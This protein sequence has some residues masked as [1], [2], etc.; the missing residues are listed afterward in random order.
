MSGRLD[1]QW[2]RTGVLSVRGAD[3]AAYEQL[4]LSLTVRSGGGSRV[5]G[6]GTLMQSSGNSVQSTSTTLQADARGGFQWQATV[7]SSGEAEVTVAVRGDHGSRVEQHL[8]RSRP[9]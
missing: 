5:T 6:P 3:F 4:M 8:P 9:G 7:I 1:V 2:D